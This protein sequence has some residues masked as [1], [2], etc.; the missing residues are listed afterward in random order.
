MSTLLLLIFGAV[1][2]LTSATPAAWPQWGGPTRN[3]VAPDAPLA[4]SWPA[5][6]PRTLWRRPLGDGF[7]GIVSDGH[8]L[9]TLY[10]DDADDV[11]V[12]LDAANGET[13]WE[14]RYAATFDETCSERLGQ[15]PR[16][17][18][19]LTGDR[20]ITVSAGGRMHSFDK[21]TGE[22]HW[23]MD[24]VPAGSDAATPCGFATSPVAYKDT[25]VTMA[26]G[27]GRGVM[28]LDV[29]TGA[30]RW[31][32]HDFTN[33]YSSPIL[34]D[35]DG[36]PEVVT[37]TAGE[38][39]GI[40]PDTGALDWTHPHPADYGVNVAMPVFG[41]DQ[42]LF[43]SSGYNGGA[44]VLKLSRTGKGVTAEEVWAH[45]RLRIHFGNAVRLGDRV[46][47]SNGD[48]GS[49]P[50]AAV[51]VKSGDM[52]WRDRSV[53]RS[54]LVAVGRRLLILDENGKLT[55]ATPGAEGLVVH[56]QAQ[57]FSG[58]SWTAPTILGTRLFARDRKEIVALELGR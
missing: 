12:S 17:A 54:T 22:Q 38:V 15:A 30:A 10:R 31:A 55:L 36:K 50:F 45:R 42:L 47:A 37:F 33:G 32:A 44:R 1:G 25:V 20:L 13:L 7:S 49:A 28:A 23:A 6:G 58:R 18:P 26:G 39:S 43:L 2:I 5:G 11:V 40:D 3:F 9:Y 14:T 19:L 56:A 46:Y 41:D 35:V 24:L 51:D 4:T 16:A 21:R 29:K 53:A 34:I 27:K 52:L 48:F 8:A 57:V